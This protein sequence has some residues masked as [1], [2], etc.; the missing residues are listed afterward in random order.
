M[1]IHLGMAVGS[2]SQQELGG[3]MPERYLATMAS[4]QIRRGLREMARIEANIRH[5][6]R[7]TALYQAELPRLGFTP[8]PNS[9]VDPLPLLWYPVR[10]ANKEQVLS[11]AAAAYVEIGSRSAI[12]LH[13]EGADTE[14]FACR[15]GMCPEAA[16]REVVDLPTLIVVCRRCAPCFGMTA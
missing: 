1:L 2:S 9:A 16:S 5:R 7:L 11:L 3:A 10:A 6:A 14:A 12:P 4:C 8:L 13:G 15:H